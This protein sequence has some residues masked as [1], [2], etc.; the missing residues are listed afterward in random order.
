M[1]KVKQLKKSLKQHYGDKFSEVFKGITADNGSEFE[2][3][4][5]MECRYTLPTH[6]AHGNEGRMSG[7]MAW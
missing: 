1:V 6:T 2:N 3:L 7:K 4:S 5:E